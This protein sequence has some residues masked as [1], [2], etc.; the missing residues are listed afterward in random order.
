[1]VEAMLMLIES[2]TK[3]KGLYKREFRVMPRVGEFITMDQPDEEG[4]PVGQI[5]RVVEV[6]H[7]AEP[8][9][10]MGDIYIVHEGN[11][12]EHLVAMRKTHTTPRRKP[13]TGTLGG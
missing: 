9:P 4:E 10:T 12:T 8:A 2:E 13:F 3:V 11:L 1:M 6:H 5:Y 7:P